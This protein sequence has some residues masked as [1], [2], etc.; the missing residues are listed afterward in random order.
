V[1]VAILLALGERNRWRIIELLN[2]APRR[3]A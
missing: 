1:D 2:L 3:S